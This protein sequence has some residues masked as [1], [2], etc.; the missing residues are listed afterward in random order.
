M[1]RV[2]DSL[3][4]SRSTAKASP[5]GTRAASP[6]RITSDPSSAISRFSRPTA[7]DSA[8][9]R[10]E[11]EQTS[12]ARFEVWWASVVRAGLISKRS[13]SWPRSASPQ[14]HSVPASPPPMI[15][16]LRSPRVWRQRCR[17]FQFD[18]SS[19]EELAK[20]TG[21]V[22]SVRI[23]PNFSSKRR[24]FCASAARSCLVCRGVMITR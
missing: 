3:K 11:F 18:G 9:E 17:W 20:L 24:M 5:A 23:S 21:W 16:I 8:E 2:T 4:T 13:T 7:L 1:A 12:S 10:N 14:A 6:H 15:L 22:M 19:E